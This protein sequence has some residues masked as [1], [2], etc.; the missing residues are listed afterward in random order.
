MI[1]PNDKSKAQ[2]ID[3]Y[4]WGN[5]ISNL[6]SFI[7]DL[8]YAGGLYDEHTGLIRFGARDYENVMRYYWVKSKLNK[9]AD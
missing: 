9:K 6:G 1:L 7:S 3:F 2:R 4:K 8:T 5:I